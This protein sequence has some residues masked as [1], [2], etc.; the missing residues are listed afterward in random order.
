MT[1]TEDVRPVSAASC[2]HCGNGII[3]TPAGWAVPVEVPNAGA[4][5]CDTS[6]DVRHGPGAAP[7]DTDTEQ[8][9][10]VRPLWKTTIVIWSEYDGTRVELSALAREAEQGDAYCSVSGSELISDPAADEGWDFT[11]FFGAD[12]DEDDTRVTCSCGEAWADEPGHD[13]DADAS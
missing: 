11:E 2:A 7:M 9:A 3:S 4:L 6:R 5:Y 1:T 8:V 12:E 13:E 10:P